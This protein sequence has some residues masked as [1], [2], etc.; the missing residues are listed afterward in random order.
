MAKLSGIKIADK[1]STFDSGAAFLL[2]QKCKV[3]NI[4][5]PSADC[6]VEISVDNPYIVSRVKGTKSFS[7]TFDLAHEA[8]QKGLDLISIKGIADLSI[9][10]AVNEYLI[11][12]RENSIQVLRIVFTNELRITTKGNI[13]LIEFDKDGKEKPPT[14]TSSAIYNESLRYFRLSQ[15][16]NDLFDAYRNMYLAF[17]LLISSKYPKKQKEREWLENALK[18]INQ[19]LPLSPI[20]KPKSPDVIKEIV[21]ELYEGIRCR[22]FHAKANKPS[23]LPHRLKDKKRVS[24]GLNKLTRLV[25]FLGK[26][27]LNITRGSGGLTYHGFNMAT[28][29]MKLNPEILF[30]KS[31]AKL[32]K[33]ETLDDPAY[34]SAVYIPARFIPELSEPGY[35]AVLGVISSA[36]L[37]SLNKV[38][39]FGLKVKGILYYVNKLESLLACDHIDRIE[40]Q[41]GIQLINL[42]E[43]KYFFKS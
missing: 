15:I 26:N 38:A 4:V 34:K 36:G 22:L 30:S 28:S 42:R 17:E 32:R 9:R 40:V 19:N 43:P 2:S 3:D 8:C 7:E 35:N 6:E 10:N 20:F 39:R 29:W 5:N 27:W 14:S 18:E 41:I 31:N 21:D 37:Q 23:L 24:E 16:T 12:W 1:R 13:Q 33:N 11:W 25:L